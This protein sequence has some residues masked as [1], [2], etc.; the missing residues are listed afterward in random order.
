MKKMFVGAIFGIVLT[1]STTLAFAL[2][3][4]FTDVNGDEWYAPA[5][6][7]LA[8]KGIIQGYPDGSFGPE[9]PTNRAE[10]AVILDRMLEYLE[11]GVV[12]DEP[13]V[14]ADTGD[15][16]STYENGAYGISFEYP[17][18]LIAQNCTVLQ[19]GSVS[20]SMVH[21]SVFTDTQVC[22]FGEGIEGPALELN[23]SIHSDETYFWCA[24]DNTAVEISVDGVT[25]YRC[26]SS[27][28]GNGVTPV[29][30]FMKDGLV[31]NLSGSSHENSLGLTDDDFVALFDEILASVSLN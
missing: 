2:G 7:N 11:T 10:L 8:S 15:G 3:T 27:Y 29:V 18:E 28:F 9:N 21:Q 22:P 4:Q 6:E 5:V 13:E 31:F 14:P 25:G 26:L 19:D 17:S 23:L 12:A 16:L 20:L 24:N 1:I 30:Q